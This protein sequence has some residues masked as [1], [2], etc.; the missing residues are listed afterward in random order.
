MTIEYRFPIQFPCL[1]HGIAGWFDVHFDEGEHPVEFST[2]PLS[3]P[4]HWCV[5][6][7]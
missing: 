6:K 1:I 5:V 7:Y 3:P 4:T 2:S